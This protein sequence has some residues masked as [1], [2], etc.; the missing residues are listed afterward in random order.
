MRERLACFKASPATSISFCTAR[1][2]PQTVAFFISFAISD[3]DSKSPGLEMGNPASIISTPRASN[4]SAKPTFSLVFSLQPGTCSPSRRVVS[5]MYTCSAM[6]SLF[7]IYHYL[8]APNLQNWA[9][10]TLYKKP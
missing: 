8:V 2:K 4:L 5:N 3:T 6:K 9:Y 1:V 7:R 10:F